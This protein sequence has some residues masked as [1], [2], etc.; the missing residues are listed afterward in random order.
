MKGM[1]LV[2]SDNLVTSISSLDHRHRLLLDCLLQIVAMG[3]T[4]NV[5]EDD[6]LHMMQDKVNLP[7]NRPEEPNLTA[8]LCNVNRRTPTSELVDVDQLQYPVC[9]HLSKLVNVD[10]LPCPICRFSHAYYIRSMKFR[11]STH[12]DSRALSTTTHLDRWACPCPKVPVRV[13]VISIVGFHRRYSQVVT[14]TDSNYVICELR[15]I[16]ICSSLRAQVQILL[17]S[18]SFLSFLGDTISGLRRRRRSS[19]HNVAKLSL[20]PR[21][22]ELLVAQGQELLPPDVEVL[23]SRYVRSFIHRIFRTSSS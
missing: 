10:R 22:E 2:D 9:P 17:A 4:S 13:I 14:A 19:G 1:R 16:S 8:E 5:F 20:P 21:V 11:M 15:N 12:L 6:V 7:E 18:L 23:E 3:V